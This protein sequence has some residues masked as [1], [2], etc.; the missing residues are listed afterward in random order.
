MSQ[1][2]ILIQTANMSLTDDYARPITLYALTTTSFPPTGLAVL[3]N[4]CPVK[5]ETVHSIHTR[6]QTDYLLRTLQ[7]KFQPRLL[8]SFWYALAQDEI[9]FIKSLNEHNF[10]NMIGLIHRQLKKPETNATQ[11]ANFI[12]GQI[13]KAESALK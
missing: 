10:S 3:Q 2:V 4:Y 9:E 7:I 8:H 12:A 11:G 1:Y 5:L 13:A 6:M